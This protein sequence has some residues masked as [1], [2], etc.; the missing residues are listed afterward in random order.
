MELDGMIMANWELEITI[1]KKHLQKLPIHS[2]KIEN[3]N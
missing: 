2:P 3:I 1:I